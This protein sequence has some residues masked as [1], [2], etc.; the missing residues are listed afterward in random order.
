MFYQE[1][2]VEQPKKRM[3]I[4]KIFDH[5]ATPP[6]DVGCWWVG[7]T[8]FRIKRVNSQFQALSVGHLSENNIQR[9]LMS[10]PGERFAMWDSGASHFLMPMT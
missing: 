7:L 10:D 8:W 9:A 3:T 5:E 2:K 1:A 6:K 4:W